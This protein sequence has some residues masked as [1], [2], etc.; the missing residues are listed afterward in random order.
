MLHSEANHVQRD[1]GGNFVELRGAFTTGA[2]LYFFSWIIE[3]NSLKVLVHIMRSISCILSLQAN[4]F[5]CMKLILFY[6]WTYT[7]HYILQFLF[8]GMNQTF[9]IKIESLAEWFYSI[10]MIIV[11]KPNTLRVIQ[12]K[13]SLFHLQFKL[14][15]IKE[16]SRKK[17]SHRCYI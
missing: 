11:T 5:F 7:C 6:S 14:I 3:K 8:L 2:T 1:H 9:F 12:H 15:L 10:H 4:T 17:R 13:C 16:D